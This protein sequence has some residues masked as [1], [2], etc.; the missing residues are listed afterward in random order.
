MQSELKIG[1]SESSPTIDPYKAALKCFERGLN[2]L[3]LA[4]DFPVNFPESIDSAKSTI[5]DFVDAVK[6]S[7]RKCAR[8]GKE[9]P[10]A[11]RGEG[12]TEAGV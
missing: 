4:G 12:Y 5:N 1:Y 7:E 3:Q 2:V 11:K 9:T 6:R 10:R 8:V